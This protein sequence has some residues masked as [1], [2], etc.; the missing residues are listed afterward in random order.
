MYVTRAGPKKLINGAP[1][2]TVHAST[3]ANAECLEEY[4]RLG[5]ELRGELRREGRA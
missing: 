2:K 4:V 3:L 1:L 5:E